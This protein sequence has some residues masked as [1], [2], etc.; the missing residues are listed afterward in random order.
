MSRNFHIIW[1]GLLAAI[2][3]LLLPTPTGRPQERVGTAAN[4]VDYAVVIFVVNPQDNSGS[5]ENP[6]ILANNR[7][8]SV[9]TGAGIS[10]EIGILTCFHIVAQRKENGF[11][12]LFFPKQA[13]VIN[14]IIIKTE[15]DFDLA[16]LDQADKE[17]IY[18]PQARV[19]K[20]LPSYGEDISF[21]GC[22]A[23]QLAWVRY[24]KIGYISAYAGKD[25]EGKLRIV[26]QPYI[27]LYPGHFGDS[28]GGVFNQKGELIGI[29]QKK[30][31]QM[32]VVYALPL[33]RDFLK[34]IGWL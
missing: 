14:A 18:L 8:Y 12:F 33:T 27:P 28:G 31:N 24:Q 20:E 13:K 19:A 26:E 25:T 11:I 2:L 23:R 15:P 10:M 1:A 34:E 6:L 7:L 29:I 4:I 30:D 22:P 16:L 17:T 21:F 3:F 5:N 32:P 9:N